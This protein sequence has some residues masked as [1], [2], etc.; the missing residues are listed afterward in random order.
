[1]KAI[2]VIDIPK[3]Y[4]GSVIDVKLYSKTNVVH[5]RYV[6]KL[7][8]MPK[9]KIALFGPNHCDIEEKTKIIYEINGYNRC[10]DEILGEEK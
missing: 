1:M 2:L 5:E 3:E 6:N 4:E 9:R 7:K 10:I 8:P